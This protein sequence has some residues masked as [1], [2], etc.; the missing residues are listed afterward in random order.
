[1]AA[2]HAG[3]ASNNS[4]DEWALASAPEDFVLVGL[5]S[6]THRFGLSPYPTI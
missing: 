5:K 4:G 6:S 1:L 2:R 3:N